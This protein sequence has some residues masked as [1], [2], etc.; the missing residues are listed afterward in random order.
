MKKY[1][2]QVKAIN[3]ENEEEIN[4]EDK[5]SHNEFFIK[6][7]ELNERRKKIRTDKL[8]MEN[9]RSKSF[10]NFNKIFEAIGWNNNQ[11]ERKSLI[12]EIREENAIS[13]EE[14]EGEEEEI[15]TVPNELEIF[16]EDENFLEIGTKNKRNYFDDSIIFQDN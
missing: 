8:K 2:K 5:D 4:E 7:E 12:N 16:S 1:D 15:K 10:I 3:E 6:D 13:D 9:E 11:Q 14:V